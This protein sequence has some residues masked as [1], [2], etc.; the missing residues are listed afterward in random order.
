MRITI[1]VDFEADEH[2]DNNDGVTIT[3]LRFPGCQQNLLPYLSPVEQAK[4]VAM[5]SCLIEQAA[6]DKA[7]AIRERRE[8][9]GDFRRDQLRDDK[10]MGVTR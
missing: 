9:A 1:E 2:V 5:V 3:A 6:I 10:L 4:A 8:M 7:D